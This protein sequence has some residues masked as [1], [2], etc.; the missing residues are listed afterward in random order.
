MAVDVDPA[1]VRAAV[2]SANGLPA[3]GGGRLNRILR[4]ARPVLEP[5]AAPVLPLV[6]RWARRAAT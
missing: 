3:R 1:L 6:G 4:R 5:L 2:A